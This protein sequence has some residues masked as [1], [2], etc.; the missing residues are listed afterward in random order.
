MR[1]P[2]S[3]VRDNSLVIRRR[4]R[5][6]HGQINSIG[7]IDTFATNTLRVGPQE[8]VSVVQLVAFDVVELGR[9][10]QTA[11]ATFRAYLGG[12]DWCGGA[13]A[14]RDGGGDTGMYDVVKVEAKIGTYCDGYGDAIAVCVADGALK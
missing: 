8:V 4:P 6:R 2:T 12:S 11:R 10:L 3:C 1:H 14:H 13:F 7:P 5:D 9:G